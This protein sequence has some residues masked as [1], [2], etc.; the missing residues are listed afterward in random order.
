[1]REQLPG[2]PRRGTRNRIRKLLTHLIRSPYRGVLISRDTV[3]KAI[4]LRLQIDICQP[5]PKAVVT[6]N[7][8]R[9]LPSRSNWRQSSE[10]RHLGLLHT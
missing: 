4:A 3:R 7:A 10:W 2:F 6:S 8:H 9:S 5:R 1:M